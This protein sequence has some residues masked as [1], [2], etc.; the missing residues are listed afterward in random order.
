V[1][2]KFISLREQDFVS[3]AVSYNAPAL[4]IISRHLIPN[5]ISYI[6]INLTLTIPGM[7]IGETSLSFL[8]IGLRPPV[9]SLGVLLNQAQSFQTVSLYPWMMLPGFIVIVVVLCYNFV[10]DG[11]RDSCDPYKQRVK[12][13]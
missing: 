8:G 11:L 7:I 6:I 10:G 13:A 2:S 4:F 9:V 1:R 5:F 12:H 3:A